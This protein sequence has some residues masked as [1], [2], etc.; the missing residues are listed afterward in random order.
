M[1]LC[2][3]LEMFVERSD[4]SLILV[5][6]EGQDDPYN[7]RCVHYFVDNGV[8]FYFWWDATGL[9]W[10]LSLGVGDLA[11]TI[12]TWSVD[13]TNPET[14]NSA[15]PI[16][17][18]ANPYIS[19]INTYPC[20][21]TCD[22]VLITILSTVSPAFSIDSLQSTFYNNRPVYPFMFNGLTYYL[23]YNLYL[24]SVPLSIEG[25]WVITTGV[26]NA[27]TIETKK[28]NDQ[29][30][31]NP[32]VYP[33]EVFT[34]IDSLIWTSVTAEKG[35]CGCV[36][37]QERIEKEYFSIQLPVVFQEDDRG[38][39][40]CCETQ[41]VLAD[42]TS[43]DTWKNDINSAW[44]KLSDPSDSA[45]IL[46]TKEGTATTYPITIQN[47]VNEPNAIY[48]TIKWRDVLASDGEGCYKIEIA[49]TIGGITGNLTWGIYDL[50]TYSITRALT[51][52]RIRVIL[53]LKQHI[54]GINFTGSMVED[55]VRFNGFIGNRQPNMEL[56][57]LIYQ[58]RVVR[59]VVREN[60]DTYE[61]K[62]D[63]Y[64]ENM[65]TRLSDLYLLSEND[66]FISDYNAFNN[67]YKIQDI[68]VI[69]QDSPEIDYLDQFQRKGVLTCTVGL[70][71]KNK[72]TN[73]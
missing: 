40:K 42:P 41:L 61:I 6:L 23:W 56:D 43:E 18:I 47:F 73:Y 53:N 71:Q 21:T 10:V 20:V 63:P 4:G 14:Y 38:F 29:I 44:V 26:G 11:T 17:Y 24:T 68:P 22:C 45:T 7:G 69:V 19:T 27:T 31:R 25:A 8:T 48:R 52:A 35:A 60:L 72:K 32:C 50:Q 30:F 16:E 3:C 62:T 51:T 5:Q 12:A 34:I 65:L 13:T 37:Y 15:T 55:S 39:F 28:P 57:N 1:P 49:Y 64:T 33:D 70:R 58:N 66:M 36:P 54:E 9:E 2:F 67:S 46:L 59:T